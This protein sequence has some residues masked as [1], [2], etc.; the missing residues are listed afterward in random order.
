M[1]QKGIDKLA[2]DLGFDLIAFEELDGGEWTVIRSGD[3]HWKDGFAVPRMLLDTDT[4]VQTCN[5]K[6]HQYGGHFTMA[7][8][9]SVGLAAKKVGNQGNDYMSELHGSSYQRSMIAEINTAYR[10]DLIVMDGVEAFVNGGPAKGRKVSSEVIVAG[11]DPIA[12]DAVGVAILRLFGTTP[13]VSRGTV[14]DQEQIAR[15]VE[16]GLGITSPDQIHFV[17]KGEGSEQFA[18]QITTILNS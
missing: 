7:L 5:L 13:E 10:P 18:S 17:A 9:N 1:Q 6:T 15:A 8:K 11:T 12:I 3:F 14:F 16:L 4:V 2:S